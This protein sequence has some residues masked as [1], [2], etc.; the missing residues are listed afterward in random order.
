MDIAGNGFN[1]TNAANG[2]DFDINGNGTLD[3]LSWTAANSDDA[4]LA[5]DRN[6]NNIMD[7]G[8]ELFGNFTPQPSCPEKNGFLALAEFDK[9]ANAGNGDGN[10]TAADAIFGRLRLWQDA[11]HNGVSESDELFTLPQL[12]VHEIELD[13]RE[14]RRMD[15]FGNEFRFRSK[16]KGAQGHQVGRWAWDVYLVRQP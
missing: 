6:S 11:N 7:T 15:E 10:I 14:S 9:F 1:L 13:Y 2:V 12:G 5:L 8:R 3:S 4:W 16:V